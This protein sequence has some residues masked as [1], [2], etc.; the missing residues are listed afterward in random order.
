[1]TVRI[2]NLRTYPQFLPVYDEEEVLFEDFDFDEDSGGYV[3]RF[4][5]R[6]EVRC[7]ESVFVQ[8]SD[9]ENLHDPRYTDVD[10]ETYEGLQLCP[11]FMNLIEDRQIRV[12]RIGAEE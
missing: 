9:P 12:E 5:K 1:M 11:N 7:G 3:K 4:K 8:G 6:N 2:F 10:E